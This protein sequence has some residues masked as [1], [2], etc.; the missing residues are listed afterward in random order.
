MTVAPR[1]PHGPVALLAD[2]IRDAARCG[3]T[4]VVDGPIGAGVT[5]V[6][7][8]VRTVLAASFPTMLS[9]GAAPGPLG[10]ICAAFGG[11]S[12][13]AAIRSALAGARCGDPL[14]TAALIHAFGDW[15]EACGL[16]GR[17][18]VLVMCDEL[19]DADPH[20]VTTLTA[21]A[22][23]PLPGLVLVAGGR[24]GQVTGRLAAGCRATDHIVLP[25][26]NADDIG[27][28]FPQLSAA[29]CRA[30]QEASEGRP[31]FVGPLSVLA[32][33]DLQALDRLAPA[34]LAGLLD[35][36]HVRRWCGAERRPA[37]RQRI[38]AAAAAGG[39]RID[40]ATVADATQESELEVVST[41]LAAGD[42][43]LIAETDGGLRFGHPLLRGA[44]YR[45]AD[46]PTRAG[47][48]ERLAHRSESSSETGIE[49]LA[50]S[51]TTD[52]AALDLVLRA[53]AGRLDGDPRT[54]ARWAGQVR[55]RAGITD[56][57]RAR[58]DLL[59][60]AALAATGRAEVAARLARDLMARADTA[61]E[62]TVLAGRCERLLGRPGAGHALLTTIPPGARSRAVL[63][64]LA[65]AAAD[66]PGLPVPESADHPVPPHP[67]E[68][69]AVARLVLDT[70]RAYWWPSGSAGAAAALGST[71][72]A[73]AAVAGLDHAAYGQVVEHLPGLAL[74][75]LRLGR[76]DDAARLAGR[77]VHFA[78]Q[79][80]DVLARLRL[81]QALADLHGGRLAQAGGTGEEASELARA[82]GLVRPLRLAEA[83][84][85]HLALL[86]GTRPA[87][88]DRPAPTLER[89][90]DP[91]TRT[92][93]LIR[94][95]SALL[96]EDWQCARDTLIL[97]QHNAI[98][99]GDRVEV[100]ALTAI[101][102]AR[103]GH[104]ADAGRALAAAQATAETDIDRAALA[105][106]AAVHASVT[107]QAHDAVGH[108][109]SAVRLHA[110]VGGMT[111][112]ARCRVLL[113]DCL[114]AAGDIDAAARE[115]DLA[116]AMLTVTGA[117]QLARSA[118]VVR[119][120]LAAHR[121]RGLQSGEF[122][123]S[124]REAEIAQL[125]CGGMTNREIGTR[126]FL[127]VRTVDTHVARVLTKVGVNSRVALAHM[128]AEPATVRV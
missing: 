13:A 1:D 26:W 98:P 102:E 80:V 75:L 28:H 23:R 60:T 31:A 128:F 30:L 51:G 61:V 122:G 37:R 24:R 73:A 69:T 99:S 76:A 118:V 50:S 54:A 21:L 123:L 67:S 113:A 83:V 103:L 27:R 15:A 120:R 49:H 39:H 107:G 14:W 116:T 72:H 109:R 77:G 82:A 46:P 6:L 57:E 56:A 74:V 65:A 32:L 58:A 34:E 42:D 44:C 9:A 92:A 2:T 112:E 52:P 110:S 108:A 78:R 64:E 35:E 84:T 29:R 18:P 96:A 33:A 38:L 36:T 100:A 101:A 3:G 48:H 104:P 87:H 19:H 114:R 5:T 117:H 85:D 40:P 125:V 94:A 11:T 47:L 45:L 41:L 91:L 55:C 59:Y 16:D 71:A 68:P 127:S 88:Q 95:R 62:A 97:L 121:S 93:A 66:H 126:L 17:G 90:T 86:T 10:M 20:S 119:K 7:A 105:E 79:R 43:G 111:A 8:E 70:V 12:A 106:A 89:P 63:V 53:A 25:S 115:A 22:R 81:V 4:I 124:A